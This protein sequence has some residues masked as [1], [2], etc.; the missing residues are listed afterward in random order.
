LAGSLF[1]SAEASIAFTALAHPADRLDMFLARH[2]S[3]ASPPGCTLEQCAMKS[4]RQADLTASFCASVGCAKEGV[5]TASIAAVNAQ[6]IASRFNVSN[7]FSKSF[8]GFCWSCRF[9]VIFDPAYIGR[10]TFAGGIIFG[11]RFH[12]K[13]IVAIFMG[14][15]TAAFRLRSLL[16]KQIAGAQK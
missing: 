10:T 9:N 6:S 1:G 16:E 3:A 11:F 8:F 15:R 4:E 13:R 5:A 2:C 12:C 7:I 14:W